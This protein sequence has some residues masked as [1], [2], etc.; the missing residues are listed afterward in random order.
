MSSF[1]LNMVLKCSISLTFSC[2]FCPFCDAPDYFLLR[3][4][5]HIQ[6]NSIGPNLEHDK[7][8]ELHNFSSRGLITKY[9]GDPLLAWL[10]YA[11]TNASLSAY[12]QRFDQDPF[13]NISKSL[14]L[15]GPE[16]KH[17]V[18]LFV[19]ILLIEP[20]FP[21]GS[22]SLLLY[23]MFGLGFQGYAILGHLCI[24]YGLSRGSLTVSH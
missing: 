18:L 8:Q 16:N 13:A 20:I 17:L 12:Q 14:I 15:P 24:R 9:L 6:R 21:P 2:D 5:L 10:I 23:S 1:H 7:Y 3:T 11:A 4:I 22:K 19:L